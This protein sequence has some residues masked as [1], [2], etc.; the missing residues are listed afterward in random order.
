MFRQPI[1]YSPEIGFPYRDINAAQG[2]LPV[3]YASDEPDGDN[4]A[5]VHS[6]ELVLRQLLK[7]TFQAYQRKHR[8]GIIL[9]MDP[10]I[11]IQAFNVKNILAVYPERLVFGFNEDEISIR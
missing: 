1:L 4:K 3:M 2:Y 11:V 5:P 9:K 7:D 10:D 6:H 8:L